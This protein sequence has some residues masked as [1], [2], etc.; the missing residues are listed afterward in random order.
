M[1]TPKNSGTLEHSRIYRLEKLVEYSD[2]SVVS[3]TIAKSKSGTITLFSFDKG[4]GL[5]EHSTPFDAI[6]QVLDGEA[7]LIIGGK[8]IIAKAGETVIMPANIPHAVNAPRRFKMLLIM[9]RE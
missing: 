3:R 1:E 6:V 8:S 2:G 9:L 5:S 7:E 4:Q